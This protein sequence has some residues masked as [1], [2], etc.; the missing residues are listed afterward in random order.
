MARTRPLA[1]FEQLREDIEALK[2]DGA[3]DRLKRVAQDLKT[4][5]ATDPDRF[6]R[7]R[8][9]LAHALRD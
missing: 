5:R 4:L 8:K 3:E 9:T 1:R 6:E 7:V 2:A